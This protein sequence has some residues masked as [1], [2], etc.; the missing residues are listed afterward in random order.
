[1]AREI[2]IMMLVLVL[3]LGL[4]SG[5]S[6]SPVPAPAPTSTAGNLVPDF[7]LQGL[8]GENVSLSSLR[9]KPIMLNFWATWCGPC[10]ME[11]PYI[12]EV[13]DDEEWREQGLVIL[14][15]NIG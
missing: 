2:K 6:S 8:D 7:Q 14:A 9:G 11:M 12:Q 13:F 10:R 3:V 15:V 4:V 1:M 5:C